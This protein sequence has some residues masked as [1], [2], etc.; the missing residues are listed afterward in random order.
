MP[1]KKITPDERDEAV[2]ACSDVSRLAHELGLPEAADSLTDLALHLIA[3]S[4]QP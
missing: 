3:N 4:E 1:D 2:R